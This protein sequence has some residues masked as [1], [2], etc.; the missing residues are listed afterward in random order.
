MFKHILIPTDGSPVAN[1][2]VEAGIRFA[3]YLGARVTAYH[4]IEAIHPGVYGEG[5]TIGSNKIVQT[6][7]QRAKEMGVRQIEHVAKVAKAAGV[8][9]RGIVTIAETPYEGIVETASKQKCDAIFIA[10]RGRRG[11]AGLILGS[12]TQKVLTHSKLPVLVYR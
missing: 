1:K 2:A 10:S 4:A 5:Y 12:V 11:L 8:P 9:F 6:L 3:K 7:T